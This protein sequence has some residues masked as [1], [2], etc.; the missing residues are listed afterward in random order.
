MTT[1]AAFGD[2]WVYGD[3]L[4]DPTI[5]DLQWCTDP[6]NDN[7]RL[8]HGFAGLTASHYRWNL[9]NHGSNGQSLQSMMW[10]FDW[11]LDTKP[12]L[13]DS[14]VLVGLTHPGRHSWWHAERAQQPWD[15][16]W[17]RYLHSVWLESDRGNEYG[18]WHD[19]HKFW[20]ANA[21]ED[22]WVHRNYQTAVYF[23]SGICDRLGLPLVMFNVF[24]DMPDIPHS[25]VV[26]GQSGL[27]RLL[28]DTAPPRQHPDG[29]W[30]KSH[31]NKEGHRVISEMLISEMDR[32]ILFK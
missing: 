31:P 3:E 20:R 14:V 9:E 17:Y 16:P 4:M 7:Y 28:R 2:S 1:L 23:F 29:F 10:T 6:R 18:A 11:W 13:S 15:P 26:N 30:A 22:L 8:S 24:D 32:V 12:D 21:T 19:F 25:P 27:F 5:A